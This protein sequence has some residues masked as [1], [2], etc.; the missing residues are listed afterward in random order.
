ME[1]RHC[2]KCK[3]TLIGNQHLLCSSC[4]RK[5]GQ[6]AGSIGSVVI[7]IGAIAIRYTVN[8]KKPK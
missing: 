6:I 7:T 1:T 4:R 5:Y 2:I 8:A 3:K